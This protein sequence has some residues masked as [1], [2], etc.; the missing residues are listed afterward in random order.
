MQALHMGN[1]GPML[2]GPESAKAN[3]SMRH[4]KQNL[5]MQ[6]SMMFCTLL[7]TGSAAAA[8]VGGYQF[9][10]S[11]RMQGR[12]LRLNGAGVRYKV[13]FSVYSAG[14]YLG[15]KQKQPADVYAVPGPKRMRI[16]MLR[17]VNADEFGQAFLA[18]IEQNV[19]KAE[20]A[21]LAEPLARFGQLFSVI[22]ELKKGDAL[23]ID[24]LPGQGT[25]VSLNGRQ[26][27]E[28]IAEPAFYTVLLKIWLGERPADVKLKSALLGEGDG[29]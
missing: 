27:G 24:F 2:A 18:G 3:K 14:L 17:G 4:S 12:D 6:L 19:D 22:P 15:E 5:K 7:V 29:A 8:T 11:I 20:R 21:R 16:V 28:V 10:D 23:A 25:S 26:V 13:I 9:D 1:Q